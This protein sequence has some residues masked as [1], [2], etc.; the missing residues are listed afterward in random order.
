MSGGFDWAPLPNRIAQISLRRQPPVAV[1]IQFGKAFRHALWRL[2]LFNAAV[3]ILIP[4]GLS[5]QQWCT[6]RRLDQVL[7]HVLVSHE[8]GRVGEHLSSAGVVVMRVAVDDILDG[9]LETPGELG[10]QPRRGFRVGGI[11]EDDALGR[12]EEHPVVPDLTES[13]EVPL[14]VDDLV[15][16]R[17]RWRSRGELGLRDALGCQQNRSHSDQNARC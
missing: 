17:S 8:G 1:E 4:E 9:N 2:R 15:A 16:R 14:Q 3:A 7:G 5:R 6:V 11:H 12:V 13:I 10:L